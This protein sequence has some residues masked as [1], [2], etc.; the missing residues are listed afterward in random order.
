MGR[1]NLNAKSFKKIAVRGAI[2]GFPAGGYYTNLVNV[3]YYKSVTINGRESYRSD[4]DLFTIS[5]IA[6]FGY[7]RWLLLLDG[8]GSP[9]F[10]T[11]TGVST[12]ILTYPWTLSWFAGSFQNSPPSVKLILGNSKIDKKGFG[13][14]NISAQ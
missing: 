10:E 11:A 2:I 7:Q 1:I 5:Y 3:D 6:Q 8:Y 12:Q 4:N 9:I 13:K 14:G